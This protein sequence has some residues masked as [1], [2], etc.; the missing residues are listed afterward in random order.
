MNQKNDGFKI[1]GI[2]TIVVV[3]LAIAFNV[4]F[5]PPKT[6]ASFACTNVTDIVTITENLITVNGVDCLINKTDTISANS[7]PYYNEEIYTEKFDV[8]SE[9]VLD[10]MCSNAIISEISNPYASYGLFKSKNEVVVCRPLPA[11]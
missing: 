8:T 2:G 9:I 3:I 11:I 5:Q 4:V 6:N 7:G 1:V 10:E